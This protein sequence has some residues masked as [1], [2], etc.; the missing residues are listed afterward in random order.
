MIRSQASRSAQWM[1]W[2]GLGSVVVL[3]AILSTILRRAIARP[4][5]SP[6][7]TYNPPSA[8]DRATNCGV[9]RNPSTTWCEKSASATRA[10]RNEK[11]KLENALEQV[12]HTEERWRAMT[13]RASDFILL[14]DS[15]LHP[16]YVSPSI[17]AI[18]GYGSAEITGKALGELVHHED[19][20]AIRRSLTRAGA[21]GFN[22]GSR[23]ATALLSPAQEQ[24]ASLSRSVGIESAR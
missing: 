22:G 5:A 7:G 15:S 18:L 23:A 6:A 12:G 11:Q 20:Y 4:R 3:F 2:A 24:R 19:R 10:L 16:H 17:E 1:L 8:A 9:W 13:E 21:P 14:L